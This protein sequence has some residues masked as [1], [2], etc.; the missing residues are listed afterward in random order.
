MASKHLALSAHI[1]KL[2]E[3]RAAEED[4]D[5]PQAWPRVAADLL[6]YERE[7][8]EYFD[9]N[10]GGID[11]CWAGNTV[12]EVFQCKMHLLTDTGD[13]DSESA[14]D[15]DGI[16]DLDRAA[17]F[18]FG[19]KV[20]A[21]IDPRLLRLRARIE[22]DLAL[23]PQDEDVPESERRVSV[24]FNL[25]LLGT[26]MTPVAHAAMMN[27]RKRLRALNKER[28]GLHAHLELWDLDQ[29]SSVVDTPAGGGVTPVE[30][31]RLRLA[32]EQLKLE[33][34]SGAEIRTSDFVTFFSPAADI[35]TA[36]V[37]SGPA[38]FDANVRY[39]LKKSQVN[40]EIRR[41]AMH[42]KTMRVFHL[43]NNGVTIAADGW[44][45]KDRQRALEIRGPSVINGCQTV[46]SLV[47][48]KK[49]LDEEEPDD[50]YPTRAF[51]KHCTVLVR[52]IRKGAVNVEDV[53]RAAN[54]Q[55]A[56]EPRNLLGNRHEQ[57]QLERDLQE[58]GWFYE[59]KDGAQDALREMKRSSLGTPLAV[60][61]SKESRKLRACDNRDVARAWLSFVGY[62]DEG[63]NQSNRHFIDR[64]P[65]DLYR[66]IFLSTPVRH[67]GMALLDGTS[68]GAIV[69]GRPPAAWML[70]S[71]HLLAVIK[72]L[73]P[74]APKLRGEVRRKL[75][76]DGTRPTIALVNQRILDDDRLRLEFALS[77]LDH[78]VLELAG[79]V[80][81]RALG[82]Q[83]L[84]AGTAKKA[85]RLGGLGVFHET[86]RLPD[87]IPQGGILDL[88]ATQLLQDPSLLSIRLAVKGVEATLA[89]P[90]YGESFRSSERKSRYLQSETVLKQ[91]RRSVDL[92]NK[93][94]D[95]PGNFEDWWQGGSP[96]DAIRKAL[97]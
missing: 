61:R 25:V 4:L 6:G 79:F 93:Y 53:V 43:Y 94:F 16:T 40:E 39:E 17:T 91:Y 33:E 23:V 67:G 52:L 42:P 56:M 28:R 64:P 59:R 38:L 71:H 12:Y 24:V 81:A 5:H 86:G 45:Y 74:Q 19:G 95:T 50:D 3:E 41:S 97:T 84:A 48:A 31:I 2:I 26:K 73:L 11:F 77:M 9:N 66:K 35:V 96:F 8:I 44:A 37:K 92:Y 76:A 20:S 7:S 21:S 54:T 88:T 27:L 89:K 32:M 36:A 29:L 58:W 80:F 60:F 85:L 72:R 75:S 15:A 14:F 82:L 46:R 65:H 63:K 30:P 57:R 49:E 51:E 34:P 13:V 22:S 90:E 62:S 18:L 10:D 87:E 69:D 83:W 47:S 1:A 78:V 55:N 68:D 70:F